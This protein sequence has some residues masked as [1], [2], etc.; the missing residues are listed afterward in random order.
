MLITLDPASHD[1][2][3]QQI[4]DQITAHIAAGTI[5]P[6][7]RLPTAARLADALDVNRNTVLEAYRLLRDDHRI[8][9]RRGRGAIALAPTQTHPDDQALEQIAEIARAHN[10]TTDHITAYLK[11]TL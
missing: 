2:L 9:L 4:A 1:P 5:A 8:E 11:D 7:E 10:L 6:G 3:Y